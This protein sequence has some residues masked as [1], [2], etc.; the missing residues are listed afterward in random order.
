MQKNFL[1]SRRL[2]ALAFLFAVL[3]T[4]ITSKVFAQTVPS[5][6]TITNKNVSGLS[7]AQYTLKVTCD[8]TNKIIYIPYNYSL[9]GQFFKVPY[10]TFTS[11]NIANNWATNVGAWF[12]YEA[13]GVRFYDTVMYAFA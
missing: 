12:G 10:S 4:A 7:A 6:Y 11:T 9:N 3:A 2:I 1:A 8:P 5:G 13:Q